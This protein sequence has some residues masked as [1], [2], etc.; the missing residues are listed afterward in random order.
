MVS[1]EQPLLIKANRDEPIVAPFSVGCALPLPHSSPPHG[2]LIVR[3]VVCVA[4]LT[5]L[6]TQRASMEL[7]DQKAIDVNHSFMSAF[8]G[9]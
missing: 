8:S 1:Q 7:T 5:A 3:V 4:Q 9:P 2:E 6:M